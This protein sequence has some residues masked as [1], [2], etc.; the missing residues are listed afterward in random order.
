LKKLIQIGFP[1]LIGRETT[2]L[3][4]LSLLLV[5]RTILSIQ[6]SDLNGSIVK[7]IVKVDPQ[8]FFVKI[9]VLMLYSFPSSAVNSGLDY[10]NKLLA[11]FLRENLTL[12]FHEKYLNKM[13]F[14]QV[15]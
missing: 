3:G 5:I 10:L 6:V 12:Y 11:L 13:C 4:S 1:K 2:C 14:Y 15:Q 8:S 9:I 7:A